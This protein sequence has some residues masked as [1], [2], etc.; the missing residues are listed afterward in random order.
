ML[1]LFVSEEYMKRLLF[2]KRD[3]LVNKFEF[4]KNLFYCD[5]ILFS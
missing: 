4:L 2:C 1:K 3:G 5:Y